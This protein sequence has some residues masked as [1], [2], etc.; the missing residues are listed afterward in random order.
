M[1]KLTLANKLRLFIVLLCLAI[2]SVA[3]VGVTLGRTIHQEGNQAQLQVLASTPD[4]GLSDAQAQFD[5]GRR[6][7]VEHIQAATEERCKTIALYIYGALFSVLL[8]IA[9][10]TEWLV[11]SLR[12]SLQA[13]GAFAERISQGDLCS[14]LEQQSDDEFGA[15]GQ[16]LQTMQAS[17][18]GI[19]ADVRNASVMVTHVGGQLVA[20]ALQLSQQTQS[21]ATSLERTTKNVGKV[22]R[23]VTRNSEGSTEVSLMTESL[24]KEAQDA[25]VLME[26]AMANMPPLLDIA[27]RMKD[28]I[29]TIDGI[30]F[31]TNLLALNAA[32]EAARAGDSGKG[33]AVVATEVR[34]LARRSQIAATQIR[35]MISE[36]DTR[37]QRVVT[38]TGEVSRLMTS[39]VT[40]IKEVAGS[41]SSIADQSAQQSGALEEVVQSVGDLDRATI[42]N[43]QL[44]DHTSH[45]AA[46]LAQRSEELI[47]A[48]SHLKLREGT[49]DEAMALALRAAEHVRSVGEAQAFHD[50]HDPQGGFIDRDLYIFVFDR[51]GTYSALGADRARVG[52]NVA[53]MT[54]IDASQMI[55]DA[56]S[57]VDREESGW[58]EYSVVNPVSGDVRVKS[59]FV[60]AL[61]DSR[62]IGCGA[63]RSAIASAMRHQ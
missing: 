8:M 42:S 31:Q 3:V 48:V 9:V 29:S 4:G 14:E 43:S 23:A 28:I 53:D 6:L 62:L 26:H 32:V 21:Q 2:V 52:G 55:A 16:S 7:Q 47:A 25:S 13:A 11:R 17:L 20:D 56:W 1:R 15:L 30:A 58:V 22:S 51:E 41:V 18:S 36:T 59:S 27:S 61:D 40:G 35:T 54:G 57:R 63:Y 19:V 46:K 60:L 10:G 49:A 37:V 33:F 24:E 34:Q 5:A 39:L 45:K 38:D 44:V 12:N 50:F